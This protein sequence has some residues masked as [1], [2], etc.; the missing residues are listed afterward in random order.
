MSRKRQSAKQIASHRNK[1][2]KA[3][4]KAGGLSGG[5]ASRKEIATMAKV[6]ADASLTETLRSM[7]DVDHTIRSEGTRNC[8]RWFALD[9]GDLEAV[10]AIA[11]DPPY[12]IHA[13]PPC[14][15]QATTGDLEASASI[16]SD[17]VANYIELRQAVSNFLD[18]SLTLQQL[19]EALV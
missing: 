8:T 5:G 18:G 6:K 2:L 17:T 16:V 7:R 19:K 4:K 9:N 1:I 15:P 12:A 3:V 14:T 10:K 13:S 11:I